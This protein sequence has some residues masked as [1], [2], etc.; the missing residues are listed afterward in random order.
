MNHQFDVIVVGGGIVGLT[1]ALTIARQNLSVAIIDKSDLKINSLRPNERVFAINQASQQLLTL[2]E[3]WPLIDSRHLSP[4]QHMHIWDAANGASIDFDAR[5]IAHNKLGFIVSE[6]VLKE[7]LLRKIAQNS[8]ITLLAQQT[9]SSLTEQSESINIASKQDSWR[10]QLVM[11]ADGANSPCR[12]LLQIPMISWPYHQSALV[13]NV[14][15]EKGHQKTAY[16]VFN[17]DGPLAFLPLAA[18][19]ECSIV[20]S[21]SS[22]H[23]QQLLTLPEEDFNH[24]LTQAFAAKL[25]QV[26]VQSPRYQ[27]PLIMRHAKNYVGPRWVLLGDAAHTIHPLAGLGLNLGLADVAF[28]LT[29]LA[30]TPQHLVS[31]KMLASFQRQRKAEVWQTIALMGA[32]KTLFA[33]PLIPVAALRGLGLRFCDQLTPLKRR[34]I[35]QAAGQVLLTH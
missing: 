27:F 26:R 1:A 17:P 34:L 24:Q 9:I 28:W 6:M 23:A 16:Q 5:M 21:T 10:T 20:W 32:L 7:A 18:S 14:V 29:D 13:T 22:Q 12:Q 30:K 11:I 4:Y 15:T 31:K 3:V 2:L 33:N 25:G 19:H 8:Q 35:E